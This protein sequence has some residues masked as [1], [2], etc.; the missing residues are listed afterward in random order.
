MSKPQTG[1]GR[2]LEQHQIGRLAF[3]QLALADRSVTEPQDEKLEQRPVRRIRVHDQ[4]GRHGANVAPGR[5]N[6]G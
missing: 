4:N 2:R 3:A 1:S 6:G 5:G